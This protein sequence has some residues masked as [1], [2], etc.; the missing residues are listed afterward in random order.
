MNKTWILTKVFLKDAIPSRNSVR[1]KRDSK[2]NIKNNLIYLLAF[3][4][5]AIVVAGFSYSII[6]NL[7]KLNLQTAFIGIIFFMILVQTV[8]QTFFSALSFMYYST[9][10]EYLLPLPIKPKHIVMARTNMLII[11]EYFFVIIVGLIPLIIYGIMNKLEAIYY[12]RMVAIL[13][14]FPIIP[15]IFSNFLAIIIMSFSKKTHSKNKFQI[16]TYIIFFVAVFAIAFFIGTEFQTEDKMLSMIIDFSKWIEIIKDKIPTLAFAILG[17]ISESFSG[18]IVNFI[19]LFFITILAYIIYIFFAEKLYLKGVTE[20]LA[21]GEKNKKTINEK[22]FS[23]KTTLSKEYIKKEFR[24]LFRNPVFFTQCVLPGIIT[25]ILMISV[26]IISMLSQNINIAMQNLSMSSKISITNAVVIICVSQ[27][28]SSFLY[29]SV[30][31]ISREGQNAKYMKSIPIQLEQQINYK[32]MPNLIISTIVNVLITLF[33]QYLIKMPILYTL[34]ILILLTEITYLQNY[35]LIYI[36]ILKPKLSWNSEYAVVK[37]NLN[38]IWTMVTSFANIMIVV[39]F[40]S[41]IYRKNSYLTLIFLGIIY[42]VAIIGFKRYISKNIDK[43]F[44]KIF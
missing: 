21:N 10:N 31:A 11:V 23:K 34:E 15:L 19:K 2:S 26:F 6:D 7:Q 28:F 17:L 27:F 22:I 33:F 42:F 9:D 14:V 20:I 39:A 13:A 35:V 4:Y 41:L 30:T 24:M 38:F 32:I 1:V 8:I 12:F 40:V 5:L 44:E 36:D 16:I 18:F 3:L 37:Q 29:V 25:P 43:L